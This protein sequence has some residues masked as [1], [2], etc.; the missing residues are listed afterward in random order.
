MFHN[1]SFE[2]E[3]TD[4]EDAL[5]NNK[6]CVEAMLEPTNYV[7]DWEDALLNNEGCVEAFLGYTKGLKCASDHVET[8]AHKEVTT[9]LISE[10]ESQMSD[11]IEPKNKHSYNEF[12]APSNF[13]FTSPYLYHTKQLECGCFNYQ[14]SRTKFQKYSYLGS[15]TWNGQNGERYQNEQHLHKG[16]VDNF[17]SIS[18]ANFSK[19]EEDSFHHCMTNIFP[20]IASHIPAK[21]QDAIS[22][23]SVHDASLLA[24]SRDNSKKKSYVDHTYIDFSKVDDRLVTESSRIVGEKLYAIFCYGGALSNDHFSV[25]DDTTNKGTI[26]KLKK[27]RSD[28]FPS[29]LMTLL[30]DDPDSSI[31]S[32]LPHGRSF[33]IKN[34]KRFMDEIHHLYFRPSKFKSFQR[35]LNMWGMKVITFGSVSSN[36][37]IRSLM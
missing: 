12:M 34:Q 8:T 22:K 23:T 13:E 21:I 4:W 29:R 10:E 27:R 2:D 11:F 16:Q 35:L 6:D 17:N 25:L 15:N 33:I 9:R 28:N 14:Y 24:E 30:S 20:G 26:H 1:R 3:L 19:L 7:H 18:S 5:L 37:Y 32:W 36:I 31:I